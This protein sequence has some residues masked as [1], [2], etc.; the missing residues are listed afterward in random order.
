MTHKRL[1]SSWCALAAVI[2]LLGAQALPV[3]A[4]ETICDPE[5]P[6]HCSKPLLKGATAPFSGQLLSTELSITL[7]LKAMYCDDR[8]KLEL[9]FLKKD[10]GLELNLERQLR[11]NDRKAWEAKE[12]LLLDRLEEAQ[13]VSWYEHPA[14]VATVTVICT[15]LVFWGARETLKALD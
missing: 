10:L 12:A 14:F 13:G 7:G 5:Q 8:L 3:R 2:S 1:R 15:V 4:Q 11:E 9:D 6:S